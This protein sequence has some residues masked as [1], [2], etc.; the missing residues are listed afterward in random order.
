MAIKINKALT[1]E[2]IRMGEAD[3]QMRKSGNWDDSFD[4]KNTERMKEIIS[5]ISW[6]TRSKVGKDASFYS[7]LLVQHADHDVDFQQTCLNMMK[8]EKNGEVGKNEIAFL[9]DRV[10]VNLGKPI[11]Y[12]TQFYRNSEGIMT[13]RPVEDPENLD[14][15]RE[16]M[17]LEPFVEYEKYMLETYGRPGK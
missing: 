10:R 3:Q 1:E 17:N 5:E 16:D 2:V 7:W 13:C 14:K 9:E 15:R 8:K 4:R 11:L 6:P 12:G